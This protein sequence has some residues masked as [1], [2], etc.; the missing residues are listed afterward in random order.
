MEVFYNPVPAAFFLVTLASS[1]V[2]ELSVLPPDTELSLF[3]LFSLTGAVCAVPPSS[4]SHLFSQLT[5][6]SPGLGSSITQKGPLPQPSYTRAFSLGINN[7]NKT[8]VTEV[9]YN[10]LP[11]C[12]ALLFCFCPHSHHRYVHNL[13]YHHFLT[14]LSWAQI[15]ESTSLAAVPSCWECYRK[16]Q[17]LTVA[18]VAQIRS[19]LLLIFFLRCV[20][21]PPPSSDSGYFV[22]YF[23]Y[24]TCNFLGNSCVWTSSLPPM[25]IETISFYVNRKCQKPAFPAF[26]VG[27]LQAYD[28]FCSSFQIRSE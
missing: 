28:A 17:K 6:H 8:T 12:Q 19:C 16:N 2:L 13:H 25:R 7:D 22:I 4:G 5:P 15:L 1:Q 27:R 20:H 26:L 3:R 24:H 23:V 21:P 18:F 14:I 10:V 11:V 9:I